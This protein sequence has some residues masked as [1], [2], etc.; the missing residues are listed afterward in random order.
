MPEKHQNAHLHPGEKCYIS[1][2]LVSKLWHS[3]SHLPPRTAQYRWITCFLALN[4]LVVSGVCRLNKNP[5][6]LN[7]LSK[8]K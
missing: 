8:K 7:H 2:K 4:N 6:L 3:I 1:H 5:A